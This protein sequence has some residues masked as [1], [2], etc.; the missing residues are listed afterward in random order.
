MMSHPPDC[1]TPYLP[2]NQSAVMAAIL[3]I[4]IPLKLGLLINSVAHLQP[5]NHTR[6]YL[7]ELA[8]TLIKLIGLYVVQVSS[9][10]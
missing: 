4:S 2:P 10:F 8:P 6:G 3:N 7:T 1:I 5:G 9:H